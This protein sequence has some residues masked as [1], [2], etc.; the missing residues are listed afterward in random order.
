MR[1]CA[2][3]RPFGVAMVHPSDRI[4]RRRIEVAPS[5]CAP[6]YIGQVG[7]DP[8][9]RVVHL[10]ERNA[11]RPAFLG[12]ETGFLENVEVVTEK[13]Q[14]VKNPAKRG[15]WQGTS[16]VVVPPFQSP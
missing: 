15:C 16:R 13:F 1:T 14:V 11:S 12:V 4:Q 3:L 7:A 2:L 10:L 9:H 5:C 8:P 6:P